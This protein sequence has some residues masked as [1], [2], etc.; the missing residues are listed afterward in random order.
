MPVRILRP[1]AK[2][3]GVVIIFT[4]ELHSIHNNYKYFLLSKK[5]FFY[6]FLGK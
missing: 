1:Y 2:K 6:L 5:I 4:R 3:S